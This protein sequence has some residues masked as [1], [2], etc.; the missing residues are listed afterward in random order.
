MCIYTVYS[1]P[2]GDLCNCES[3][4][5]QNCELPSQVKEVVDVKWNCNIEG[6]EQTS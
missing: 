6:S 5:K 1:S 3:R 4:G 2:V